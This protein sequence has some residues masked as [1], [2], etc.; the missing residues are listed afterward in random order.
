MFEQ[1]TQGRALRRWQQAARAAAT[2]DPDALRRLQLAASAYRQP[3]EEVLH[4]AGGRL[5][6]PATGSPPD[7]QPSDSDWVWRPELWSGPVPARGLTRVASQT[8]LAA[9]VTLFHDSPINEITTRQ[10][11]NTGPADP[12]AYGLRLDVFHFAGS[13]LSLVFDLPPA[14][15]EG[16]GNR[17]IIRLATMLT[18]EHPPGVVARLN[19]SHGPN[20]EQLVQ[21]LTPE[22][23]MAIAEFDLFYA[24][25]DGRRVERAWLDLIFERP[26]MNRLTVHELTIGRRL[27]A[28]L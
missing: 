7:G 25:L 12:A 3:I 23:D 6:H 20:L 1:L 19:I 27:R 5:S 2:L 28:E 13:F 16:L 15:V 10:I 11:R 8:R 18:A 22:G 4:I 24:T 21:G 17:H 26:G 14:A 9:G